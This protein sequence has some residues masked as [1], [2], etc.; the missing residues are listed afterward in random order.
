MQ[1]QQSRTRDG[2]RKGRYEEPKAASDESDEKQHKE[3]VGEECPTETCTGSLV[4]DGKTKETYCD[5]CGLVVDDDSIDHGP[6][7]RSF[8]DSERENRKRVGQPPTPT[9][10][11]R[12]LSTKM[13][14][15]DYDAYGNQIDQG[16]RQQLSRLKTWHNRTVASNGKKRGLK[17]GLVEIKRMTSALGITGA[18]TES[19]SVILR[20][21][22]KQD[23][24]LGRS[25]EGVATASVYAAARLEEVAHSY[26]EVAAVSRVSK[27]RIRRSF[28]GLTRNIDILIPPTPPKEYI[29]RFSG[30]LD[31]DSEVSLKAKRLVKEYRDSD[32][33]E[34]VAPTSLAASAVYAAAIAVG[35]NITQTDV[36]ENINVSEPTI[37]KFYSTMLD[38]SSEVDLSGLDGGAMENNATTI[39]EHIQNKAP[40]EPSA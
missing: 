5:E 18:V 36:S 34:G 15:I 4:E 24:L 39:K 7:W 37:R 20:Q 19:A 13:G 25:V 9:M 30:K 1:K 23:L 10:H 29:D 21:A 28:M 38:M 17:K 3:S 31:L 14:N 33:C 22:S 2:S 27:K 40:A 16:R 8:N 6:D 12:G 35:V 32:I 26:S 11:D